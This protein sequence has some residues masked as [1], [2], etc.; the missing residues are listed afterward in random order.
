MNM[1]LRFNKIAFAVFVLQSLFANAQDQNYV[2]TYTQ[3]PVAKTLNKNIAGK[4]ILS[5]Q[6]LAGLSFD[7]IKPGILAIQG[8]T[9]KEVSVGL[10]GGLGI[11]A[12]VGKQL[13]KDFRFGVHVGFQRAGSEPVLK[14]ATVRFLRFFV[15]PMLNANIKI[16]DV[17]S[18]NIGLGGY[19]SFGSSFLVEPPKTDTSK[20]LKITYKPNIGMAF[21]VQYEAQV[22]DEVSFFAG[23]RF[24]WVTLEVDEVTLG[25]AKAI[26]LPQGKSTF[27]NINGGGVALQFGLNYFF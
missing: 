13:N 10:G 18:I 24:H 23:L 21:H 2:P 19:A 6:V 4:G 27:D 22:S 11:D 8:K 3:P 14:D 17:S 26:L 5:V 15:M 20:I 16:N 9:T 1:Y 7:N 25:G 12:Y